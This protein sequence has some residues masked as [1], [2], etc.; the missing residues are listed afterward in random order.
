VIPKRRRGGDTAPDLRWPA[1]PTDRVVR[2]AE[3]VVRR[4]WT[5]E[6][7]RHRDHGE[8]EVRAA[9]DDR[10][11]AYE[12]LA[13]ALRDGDP[14]RISAAHLDLEAAWDEVRASSAAY[15]Q[16]RRLL[17]AELDLLGSA[18]RRC[19]AAVRIRPPKSGLPAPAAG[20]ASDP[21]LRD[22]QLVRT[23]MSRRLRIFRWLGRLGPRRAAT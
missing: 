13:A 19:R 18:T 20:R 9:Y 21:S 3:Q 7:L 22:D 14:R 23:R 10:D 16:I 6:L 2:G 17:R 4:A 8:F 15:E 12:R 1:T 11:A 5:L